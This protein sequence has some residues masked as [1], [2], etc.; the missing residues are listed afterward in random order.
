MAKQ[1]DCPNGISVMW[2]PVNRAWFVMFGT[3]EIPNRTVLNVV[4]DRAEVVEILR[5]MRDTT[6]RAATL[7]G[8]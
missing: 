3:G 5:D 6:R 4:N 7:R 2:S 8:E 1:F